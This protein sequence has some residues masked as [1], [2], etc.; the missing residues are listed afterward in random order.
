MHWRPRL[1]EIEF[2]AGHLSGMKNQAAQALLGFSS[3][4]KDESDL[5]NALLALMIVP[6]NKVKEAE[7]DDGRQHILS[8]ALN[9]IAP[10]LSTLSVFATTRL[11]DSTTAKFLAEQSK[12]MFCRR[13]PVPI[14]P[15]IAMNS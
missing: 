7:D 15:K 13:A 9:A 5:N 8:E 10:G 11:V 12:D 3:D 1:F 6:A 4:G 14:T 2:D